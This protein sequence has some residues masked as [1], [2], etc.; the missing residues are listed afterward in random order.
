MSTPWQTFLNLPENNQPPYLDEPA[1]CGLT[2]YGLLKISGEDAAPFLQGQCTCDVQALSPGRGGVGAFCTPK[3]R[4]IASFRLLRAEWGF[5]L[6][7]AAD[8]AEAV[9]KRLQMYVLRSKVVLEDL[10]LQHGMIGLLEECESWPEICGIAVPQ[11][12]GTWLETPEALVL[13]LNDN[14]GRLL[15]AA[16]MNAAPRLWSCLSEPLL[17]VHPDVW[18]LKEIE[19]GF[20]E[21]V[22][23]TSEEF[24]PQMLNLDALGGISFQKGCYTG[25]EIVTRTHFLGQVKRRMF[26]LYYRG[27]F[28]AAAGTLIYETFD[29]EPKNLGQVIMAA[30]ESSGTYQILAVLG[31]DHAGSIQL[32]LG[33]P[34]GPK[35][36]WLPLPY[37]LES[38]RG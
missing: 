13:R 28:E 22:A 31:T 5:Y 37:P 35:L 14:T 24:L 33:S 16:D 26:R 6:L 21:I 18:R 11:T 8:L 10:T 3:G 38:P 15:V 4:V 7:L 19:A 12:P 2:R 20:P 27:E 30:P 1:Y 17:R 23:A 32:R 34:D 25:Q 29:T 36:E 9:R